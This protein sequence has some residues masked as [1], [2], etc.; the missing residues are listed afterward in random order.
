MSRLDC[1]AQN[2][3][4]RGPHGR[5]R[6]GAKNTFKRAL[7]NL[8]EHRNDPDVL[9][10]ILVRRPRKNTVQGIGPIKTSSFSRPP[11]WNKPV[12][13][14]TT[15]LWASARNVRILSAIH[16]LRRRIPTVDSVWIRIS[17]SSVWIRISASAEGATSRQPFLVTAIS[18]RRIVA[19]SAS[20]AV[21]PSR[22][23]TGAWSQRHA[24]SARACKR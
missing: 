5:L 18:T 9:I 2:D 12:D 20:W 15:R 8:R 17:A 21:T 10:R 7:R 23:V 6:L 11:R 3:R 1:I 13:K 16:R 24:A 14:I 19:P 22:R 4:V